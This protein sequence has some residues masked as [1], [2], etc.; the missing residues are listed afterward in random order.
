[1]LDKLEEEAY[2]HYHNGAY[3]MNNINYALIIRAILSNNENETGRIMLFANNAPRTGLHA[4]KVRN[5]EE[6]RRPL[7]PLSH[8]F[9]QLGKDL[10]QAKIGVDLYLFSKEHIVNH[11][12][13]T[14]HFIA[15]STGGSAH[16]YPAYSHDKYSFQ[17]I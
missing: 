16:L 17:T 3:G 12:L 9:E 15:S 14:V 2:D 8:D 1:M 11:E 5:V 4:L 10:L 7:K 6:N 13:S